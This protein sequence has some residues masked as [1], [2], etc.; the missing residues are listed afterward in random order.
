VT[1]QCGA[2]KQ[3]LAAGRY[4]ITVNKPAYVNWSYGQTRPGA[5][6]KPIVLLD[7]QLAEN[8]DIRLPRGGVITGRVVDEFG[9]PVANAN[10]A[11]MRQQFSQ[12]QRRLVSTGQRAQT[13][14]IGEYRLFGLSPGQY[15]VSSNPQPQLIAMPTANGIDLSGERS[16]FAPTYYP[17]TPD[18]AS[19]QRVTVGVAQTL[20]GIDIVL[21]PTRLA[22]VSGIA[23]DAQGR[24]MANGN[25]QLTL[26]GQ[27]NSG[28]STLGG[29]PVKQDGTFTVPNVPPGDYVVRANAMMR[30]PPAPGKAP[31]PPE[32]SVAVVTVNGDDVAGVRLTPMAQVQVTGRIVFDDP[33]AAQSVRAS[34]LRV[35]SQILN[36]DDGLVGFGGG[37]PDS[38]VHDDFTFELKAFPGRIGLRAF[39]PLLPGGPTAAGGWQLKSIR[40]NGVDIIDSGVDL[41]SQGLSG[42]EIELTNRAQQLS[43]RVTDA[44]G[45][46]ANDYVVVAFPQDRARWLSPMN[47]YATLARPAVDGTFKITTLPP[48]EYYAAA[49]DGIDLNDWQDPETLEALSRLATAFALTPGDRRTLD[50]KMVNV[51]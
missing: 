13:N 31:A 1:F 3:A 10:V 16:G 36:P 30:L 25:V 45:A 23:T 22:S 24:P 29:G 8:V 39:V 28:F 27:G 34:T 33:A 18:V 2:K 6:G 41:G 38:T 50:L 37:V 12:G 48:G 21:V 44:T 15:A 51:R 20:T 17:A 7:N 35:A 5:P 19:A 42:V 49:L 46:A 40:A 11:A 47:R 9:E 32:F 14:D 43:G 4:T 26:R